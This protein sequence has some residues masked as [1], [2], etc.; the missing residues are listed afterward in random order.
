MSRA[1]VDH[2]YARDRSEGLRGSPRPTLPLLVTPYAGT[3]D[4]ARLFKKAHLHA[5]TDLAIR[6]RAAAR[7]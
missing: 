4:V 3:T 2:A 6:P 7:G 1:P 5:V